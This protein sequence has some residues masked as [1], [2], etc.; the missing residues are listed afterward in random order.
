M[1]EHINEVAVIGCALCMLALYVLWYSVFKV[2]GERREN[3]SFELICAG[4]ALLIVSFIL[5]SGIS[6]LDD[7]GIHPIFFALFA[8]FFGAALLA[9][10]ALKQGS[11]MRSYLLHTAFISI[12]CIVGV[13]ILTY[14]PW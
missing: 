2:A 10:S 4:V 11:N 14:W 3:E 6:Y 7:L 8:A 9:P 1:L 12:V 13:L 5:G